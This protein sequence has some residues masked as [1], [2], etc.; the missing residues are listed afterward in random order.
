MMF[1]PVVRVAIASE[2]FLVRAGL[3]W[4][5]EREADFA[6]VG[7]F[8]QTNCLHSVADLEPHVLII[9][10]ED[11]DP[12]AASLAD[13]TSASILLLSGVKPA[14]P[15]SCGMVADCYLSTDVSRMWFLHALR[16]LV[17]K[18]GWNQGSLS[19]NPFRN[20]T[21]RERQV[22]DLIGAG[23]TNNEVAKQL[24]LSVRTV[25]NHRSRIRS[26]LGAFTRADLVGRLNAVGPQKNSTRRSNPG[27]PF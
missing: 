1:P 12:T 22:L 26:K 23:H 21:E 16:K 20:L 11:M 18:P 7:E 17:H 9:H 4:I 6:V 3:R 25:E 5:L 2:R 19:V 14:N 27:S 13:A 15:D 10:Q 8:D 24:N